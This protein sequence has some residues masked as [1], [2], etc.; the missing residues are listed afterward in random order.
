MYDSAGPGEAG[1]PVQCW[2]V[3]ERRP[4][5]LPG[6]NGATALSVGGLKACAVVNQTVVV[7]WTARFTNNK[8]V[9]TITTLANSIASI[10]VGGGFVCAVVRP[11][12]SAGTVWCWGTDLYGGFASNSSTAVRVRGLPGNVLEVVAGIA[13]VCALVRTSVSNDGQ[14]YCWG[15]NFDG[16]LGQG[17]ESDF[18]FDPKGSSGPLRVKG[19]A[20]VTALFGGSAGICAVVAGRR[21]FCWGDNED[22]QLS[23]T[24]VGGDVTLPTAMEGLCA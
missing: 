19:L 20:N 8:P 14:V 15:N 13:H 22:G 23:T 5:E 10:A 12:Q 9:Q 24:P 3:F 16:V 17:F 2:G 6:T 21:T 4:I 18:R 7:C 11:A 1:I